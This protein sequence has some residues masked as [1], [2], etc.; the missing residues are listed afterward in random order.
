V[1]AV[2][3]FPGSPPVHSLI[4]VKTDFIGCYSWRTLLSQVVRSA[5]SS[6]YAVANIEN[7]DA[8]SL[9]IKVK[10]FKHKALLEST[11]NHGD[12]FLP[13]PSPT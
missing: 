3:G 12:L 4:I 5:R 11:E 1:W 8:V 6:L 7:A 9:R 2:I 10:I 13:L